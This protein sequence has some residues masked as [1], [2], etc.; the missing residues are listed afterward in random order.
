MVMIG[1]V[2]VVMLLLLLRLLSRTMLHVV[3]TMGDVVLGIVASTCAIARRPM[4]VR[5]NRAGMVRFQLVGMYVD[6]L[7]YLVPILYAPVFLQIFLVSTYHECPMRS[8]AKMV[9]SIDPLPDH[10]LMV[11]VVMLLMLR[12]PTHSLHHASTAGCLR[13]VRRSSSG[14]WPMQA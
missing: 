11:M 7:L 8:P 2:V 1:M 13:F 6:L 3:R 12:I 5:H 10:V 9:V 4:I 14:L